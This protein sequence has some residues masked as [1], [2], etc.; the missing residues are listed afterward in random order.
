[1][2]LNN[3]CNLKLGIHIIAHSLGARV[4]LSAPG[5]LSTSP[6]IL[7][8]NSVHLIGAALDTEEISVN[9]S[10]THDSF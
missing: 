1:M 8:I 6:T 2:K 9:A 5:E 4:V 3:D 7:K 10:D